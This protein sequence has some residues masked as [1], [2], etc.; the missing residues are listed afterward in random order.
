MIA[1]ASA[2]VML[3]GVWARGIEPK[4]QRMKLS[5]SHEHALRGE[6]I[7]MP[8]AD[9]STTTWQ[10]EHRLSSPK[11]WSFAIGLPLASIMTSRLAAMATK[12]SQTNERS[13]ASG[14]CS[15]GQRLDSGLGLG[16]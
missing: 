6:F 4:C 5:P 11:A 3:F 8:I 7:G 1:A 13:R 12:T 14:R 9:M 2:G 15:V 16:G 10:N